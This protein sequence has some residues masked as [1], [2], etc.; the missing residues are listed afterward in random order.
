MQHASVARA[1]AHRPCRRLCLRSLKAHI[2][3]SFFLLLCRCCCGPPARRSLRP[4]HHYVPILK[5]SE[6]DV[7]PRIRWAR[8]HEAQVQHIVSNANRFAMRYATYPARVLYWKYV[9]LAYRS[10]IFGMDEYFQ[11]SAST[12]SQMEVL[13]KSL[14]A[15]KA[16]PGAAA[17]AGGGAA[18]AA[19]LLGP[20][21][22]ARLDAVAALAGE[23]AAAAE[24]EEEQQQQM[25]AA[26]GLGINSALLEL[27]G[28]DD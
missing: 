10:L 14:A 23:E 1:A 20:A 16:P 24:E 15:A 13:L 2:S 7:L 3:L 6:H 18:A 25:G 26:A 28:G 19:G 5:Q 8:Q 27:A 21:D 11:Q 4:Y 12:G 22:Q 17:G 9:L